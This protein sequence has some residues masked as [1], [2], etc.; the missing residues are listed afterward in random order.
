MMEFVDLKSIIIARNFNEMF[1]LHKFLYSG[2]HFFITTPLH[3]VSKFLSNNV[4]P[5]EFSLDPPQF[6]H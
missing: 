4:F 6:R 2:R 1:E 3:D 5:K